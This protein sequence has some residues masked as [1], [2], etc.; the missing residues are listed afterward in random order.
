MNNLRHF[1]IST[2]KDEIFNTLKEPLAENINSKVA[3]LISEMTN[4][5]GDDWEDNYLKLAIK[6]LKEQL[7]G[8]EINNLDIL[9][10]TKDRLKFHIQAIPVILNEHTK[11]LIETE[12]HQIIDPLVDQFYETLENEGVLSCF[13]WEIQK[14]ANIEPGELIKENEAEQIKATFC[15]YLLPR[16]RRSI[17]NSELIDTITNGQIIDGILLEILPKITKLASNISEEQIQKAFHESIIC[18]SKSELGSFAEKIS[19][20]SD[21]LSNHV[22]SVPN[23][24]NSNDFSEMG[25]LN[26]EFFSEKDGSDAHY[27]KN[28]IHKELKEQH[29]KIRQDDTGYTYEKIFGA[30]LMGAKIIRIQ[31]PYIR[32]NFQIHNFIRLC[33]LIAKIGDAAEVHLI[34]GSDDSNQR[35]DIE[36]KLSW[37]QKSLEKYKVKLFLDFNDK[38]HDRGIYLDNGWVIKIGRGLDIYQRPKNQFP[39][40]NSNFEMC[41]CKETDVDIYQLEN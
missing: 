19:I 27:N 33:K 22:D 30:Y 7:D 18:Y 3:F 32:K 15:D 5:L 9:K 11:E 20:M 25:K 1:I 26:P 21:S 4:G 31:D 34:T 38:V 2:I 13:L 28:S 39:L 37:I 10:L 41:P 6:E 17:K 12:V 40:G 35:H 29:F 14:A 36:K 24:S 16:L 8:D 23:N